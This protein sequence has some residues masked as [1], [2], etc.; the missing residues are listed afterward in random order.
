M[1]MFGNEGR[2]TDFSVCSR[3]ERSMIY[4]YLLNL[5]GAGHARKF[6]EETFNFCVDVIGQKNAYSLVK[7]LYPSKLGYDDSEDLFAWTEKNIPERETQRIITQFFYPKIESLL[8]YKS[9]RRND[10]LLIR[11][12]AIQSIF[13]LSDDEVALLELYYLLNT[14]ST[15]STYLGEDPIDLNNY[16][17]LKIYGHT[18]LGMTP[19]Q[20]R[21]VLNNTILFDAGIVE[22]EGGGRSLDRR[23]CD[24][25][26]GVGERELRNTFFSRDVE[27]PLTIKDFSLSSE[28]VQV[29]EALLKNNGGCNILFYGSPGT[30][31]TSLVKAI[32]KHLKMD[33]FSVR[34][35]EDTKGEDDDDDIK[36]RLKALY[37]T[38]NATRRRKSLILVDEADELLNA[39]VLPHFETTT[40]KSWLNNLLDGHG[41][42][43][44]WIT[45]RH[46]EIDRSTMRRFAFSL[47]FEQLTAKNRLTVLKHAL[48]TEG[49]NSYLPDKDLQE[50][51][52]TYHVDASG[53]V[54][55][56]RLLK[57]KKNTRK[58]TIIKMVEAM[59]KNH[60]KATAG[61][62]RG[63]SRKRW[64]DFSTYSLKGLNTSHSLED[65]SRLL[66]D[67]TEK[68][69]QDKTKCVSLL[70]Y[71]PSGT[72]K[73]EF[74]HY[75]GKELG[76]DVLLKHAS[77]I[78]DPYVG[79]TEKNIARAFHEAQQEKSIL[80][81]D[82][83]DT[84]L[85]PRKDAMRSWEKSFT[86]E[87]LAQ[88]DGFFGI[89]VFATNDIEGLDHA[90]I[91]RFKFKVRFSA[92]T[93]EG[94]LHF[95]RTMLLPMI[96][97]AEALTAG[98]IQQ[99]RDLRNL[100]PGDYAVV[101]DQFSF[102]ST[103]KPEHQ[104]L[105]NALR[106]EVEHKKA[107]KTMGF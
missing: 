57:I 44:I 92:L 43:I 70:L 3:E 61:K 46:S 9:G 33:L 99:V 90:A 22:L 41:R 73:S 102:N 68:E 80:F 97:A 37:A 95:Y 96:L 87:I 10:E 104:G 69:E 103:S 93:P 105:I 20:F 25:L 1:M 40:N 28:E 34:V 65:I 85:F 56:V 42:K 75:L 13:K 29:M 51:C 74:V 72:G 52:K 24:Y 32:A 50:L 94:N 58:E 78:Q 54:N 100:T 23:I 101:R 38:I 27:T 83:A 98:H 82:E 17:L 107:S 66:K 76:K 5:I 67:Y 63:V 60:E 49:L 21:A 4:T 26:L 59:L 71:G 88:L 53:I 19:R 7:P 31:K 84:F 106:F 86:N 30:G 62:E 35:A 45:N 14:H 39:A 47:E 15:M 91:R 48:K 6:P 81:F 16:H 55:A 12:E 89:V 11:L 18:V 77:D 2:K 36:F 8:R 64:K 79:M